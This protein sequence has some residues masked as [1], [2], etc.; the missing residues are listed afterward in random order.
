MG[1]ESEAGVIALAHPLSGWYAG[2]GQYTKK[3]AHQPPRLQ[4]VRSLLY[5]EN[6]A[7]ATIAAS[8]C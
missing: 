5:H 7:A 8:S 3:A 2:N 4:N 6:P 1:F